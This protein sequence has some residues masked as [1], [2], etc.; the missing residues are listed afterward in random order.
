MVCRE[1]KGR[2]ALMGIQKHLASLNGGNGLVDNEYQSAIHESGHIHEGHAPFTTDEQLEMWAGLRQQIA[3][4]PGISAASKYRISEGRGG[5]PGVITRI[6]Q[7]MARLKGGSDEHGHPLRPEQMNS[8]AQMAAIQRMGTLLGRVAPAKRAYLETYARHT[9]KS[10]TEATSEWN[11][12]MSRQG[13]FSNIDLTDDFRAQLAVAG[14]T[15][16]NQADIG[17]SGKTRDTLRIMEGRRKKALAAT[18]SRHT[19]LP[20][21]VDYVKPE[22]TQVRCGDCGRFGHDSNCPNH[23]ALG[24][25][26]DLDKGSAHHLG[27]QQAWDTQVALYEAED[28]DPTPERDTQI[29]GYRQELDRIATEHGI[30]PEQV[31]SKEAAAA[32]ARYAKAQTEIDDLD[33]QMDTAQPKVSAAVRKL[34]Y[35]PDTGLLVVT[36]HPYTRKGD[37]QTIERS[38]AYRVSPHEFDRLSNAASTGAALA[39]TVWRKGARKSPNDGFKF[40]NAADEAAAYTQNKCPTCGRWAS[41]TSSHQCV[42]PGTRRSGPDSDL[43]TDSFGEDTDMGNREAL[44]MY[45]QRLREATSPTAPKQPLPTS[46]APVKMVL[47]NGQV[48]PIG[49]GM[50]GSLARP[51][52]ISE[53]LRGGAVVRTPL[54][55][56]APGGRVTGTVTAWTDPDGTRI[57]SGAPE[58]GGRG[59]ACTCTTYARTGK[60][61]HIR[62]ALGVSSRTWGLSGSTD[63]EYL[64]PGRSLAEY[65]RGISQDAPSGELERSNYQRIVAARR[66]AVDRQRAAFNRLVADGGHVANPRTVPPLNPRT[67]EPVGWPT[68]WSRGN[69]EGEEVD[70]SDAKAVQKRLRQALYSQSTIDAEGKRTAYSVIRDQDGGI[71][72]D[73]PPSKRLP[74]GNI[75]PA[76]KKILAGLLRVPTEAVDD[77]GYRIPPDSSWRHATLDRAYG[78]GRRLEPA[79]W[80]V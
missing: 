11:D 74:N 28:Q 2:S 55:V 16:Q 41:M 76:E 10:M 35:N 70:L 27:V 63:S 54:L 58:A 19:P 64:T 65:R 80:I 51:D 5:Q 8:G 44:A 14:M 57:V 13:N 22:S 20:Q 17:Q 75:P 47:T 29:N 46:P 38:Y 67:G 9:G 50:T 62:A 61:E 15:S 66:E 25:Q 21:T 4:H 73:V 53:G 49:R 3:D 39:S 7:E 48:R 23:T 32:R 33:Q 26:A 6:D 60:C 78:D 36:A 45:R 59:L 77:G 52:H 31:T 30:D 12:L 43:E 68:K 56:A 69:G 72:I 71:R 79:G 42:V 34:Q 24:R 18:P 37:G 1:N 40:E